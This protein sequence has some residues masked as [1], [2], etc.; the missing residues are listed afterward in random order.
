[1]GTIEAPVIAE[2]IITC[3]ICGKEGKKK[4]RLPRGWKNVGE[5]YYSPEC[6]SD[7]NILRAITIPVAA[8]IGITWPELRDALKIYW[9][10]T[11]K[12]SNW[13]VR[14]LAL[15]DVSRDASMTKLPTMATT[16]LY[17]E[18]RKLFP[19]IPPPSLASLEQAITAKYKAKR[20]E[21]IWLVSASFPQYRYPQPLA[22]HNKC[23]AV[24]MQG[25]SPVVD[26]NLGK[27]VKISLK[28]RSGA[29]F[30]RQ[31]SALA[32]VIAGDSKM[33][34]CALYEQDDKLMV[35]M[36]AWIPRKEPSTT[37]TASGAL[38]VRS[39]ADTLLIVVNEK[40]ERIWTYHGNQIQRWAAEHRKKLQEWADDSK[41][42]QRPVPS[43]AA[44]RTEA[45]VKYHRRINT[46]ADQAAKFVVSYARRRKFAMFM[47]DDS[48]RAYCPDFVW[49][50]LAQR[51]KILCD[52]YGIEFSDATGLLNP[53]EPA[54]DTL[55]MGAAE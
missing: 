13:M 49:F 24:R 23:W 19:V 44:R 34:E 45:S 33:G 2:T 55:T 5:K 39:A 22:L 46:A 38:R 40:D 10:E 35:K 36:V 41:V 12:A 47:Y 3:C 51:I 50:R 14:Q 1:M 8:P 17:P 31:L 27:D 25:D 16:Y 15:K 9:R 11:T 37:A 18:A 53:A 29:R 7:R 32:S 54:G 52:E 21:L 4:R 30:R 42:E 6:W 26:L 28:L 43:F 48:D 20:R